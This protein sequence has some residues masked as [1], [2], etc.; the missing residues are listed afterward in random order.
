MLSLNTK[1]KNNFIK[2]F[3]PSRQMEFSPV[4]VTSDELIQEMEQE[5]SCPNRNWQLEAY[6]D[7]RQ[8]DEFWG[9]VQRDL[10][11]DPEWSRFGQH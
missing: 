2:Y 10:H 3:T 7:V 8:L 9:R 1:I 11:A 6:Q 5:R 4:R